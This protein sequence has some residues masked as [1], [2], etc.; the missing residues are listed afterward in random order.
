MTELDSSAK[1]LMKE[2]ASVTAAQEKAPTPAPG[3]DIYQSR[4]PIMRELHEAV[5]GISASELP[6]LIIGEKGTGKEILGRL[7]HARQGGRSDTFLTVPCSITNP[8]FLRTLFLEVSQAQNE[9]PGPIRSIFLDDVCDLTPSSQSTLLEAL[10]NS[11]GTYPGHTLALRIISSTSRSPEE[12]IQKRR[13]REDLFYRLNGISL[14]VP[15]LR[16]RKEDIPSLVNYFL[17]L[18]T[19]PSGYPALVLHQDTMQALLQHHWPGNVRELEDFVKTAL[20]SGERAAFEDL[21]VQSPTS[22]TR[23]A[24]WPALPLKE[25]TRNASRQVERELILSTLAHT[26]W[27]RKRAAQALG[28]SYKALLYK[29]KR[30]A[31]DD[32]L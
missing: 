27:N 2:N 19:K 12:E 25:A 1:H 9:P 24:F 16:Y 32:S 30:I 3:P 18:H 15:P 14:R 5:A 11:D 6:I 20:L 28:I 13:L 8:Q 17:A 7:I 10:N 26:R 29:L 21:K 4:S 22:L 31:L 23:E